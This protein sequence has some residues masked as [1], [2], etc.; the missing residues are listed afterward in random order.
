MP[1]L[2]K[3]KHEMQKKGKKGTLSFKGPLGEPISQWVFDLLKAFSFQHSLLLQLKLHLFKSCVIHVVVS[4][5]DTHFLKSLFNFQ[6]S[7]IWRKK[8]VWE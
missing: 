4:I 2:A 3:T 6:M 1:N 8:K 7:N 5:F